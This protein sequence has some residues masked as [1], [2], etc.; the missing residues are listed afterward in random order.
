MSEEGAEYRT[1]PPGMT[2][3]YDLDIRAKLAYIDALLADHDRKRQEILVTKEDLRVAV[4]EL[5]A[6]IAELKAD[7]L[8]PVHHARALGKLAKGKPKFFS[9]EERDRRRERLAKVRHLRWQKNE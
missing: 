6:E 2:P 9:P 5:K 4:A 3:Q 1:C 7:L 8:K